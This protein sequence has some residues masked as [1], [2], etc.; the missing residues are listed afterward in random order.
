[1]DRIP[2]CTGVVVAG[3][4]ARRMGG[5]PKGLLRLGGETLAARTVRLFR[6]LFGEVL[7]AAADPEPWVSLGAVVVPDAIPGRGAAGGLQAAV[8]MCNNNGAC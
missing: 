1:M 8:E 7:V 3:G 6:S 2:D 4:R 5:T